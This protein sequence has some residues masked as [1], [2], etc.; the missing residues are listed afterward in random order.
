[1]LQ[2]TRPHNKWCPNNCYKV[3]AA[4]GKHT[5]VSP[6]V[7]VMETPSV[8]VSSHLSCFNL[9]DYFQPPALLSFPASSHSRLLK[10]LHL[11]LL[12]ITRHHQGTTA[13][14]LLQREDLSVPPPSIHPSIHPSNHLS[15]YPSIP[16]PICFSIKPSIYHPS[17]HH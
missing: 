12:P 9:L 3:T 16:P 10:L 17:F 4:G 6:H 15:L 7:V 8:S 14:F 5:F 2:I 11:F 13:R 1:M